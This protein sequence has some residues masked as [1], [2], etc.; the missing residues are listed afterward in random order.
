MISGYLP[1]P[2]DVRELLATVARFATCR[3]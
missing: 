2:F 1:K 3:E